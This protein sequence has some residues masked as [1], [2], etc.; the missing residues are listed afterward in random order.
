M[1]ATLH[2][3]LLSVSAYES[4]RSREVIEHVKDP[5]QEGVWDL[6]LIDWNAAGGCVC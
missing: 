5:G 3:L 4:T 6:V 2:H 1:I